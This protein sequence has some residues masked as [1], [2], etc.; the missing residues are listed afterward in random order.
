MGLFAL[1]QLFLLGSDPLVEVYG[2]SVALK[3]FVFLLKLELLVLEAMRVCDHAN[4]KTYLSCTILSRSTLHFMSSPVPISKIFCSLRLFLNPNIRSS[5]VLVLKSWV[6]STKNWCI[7]AYQKLTCFYLWI[8][9]HRCHSSKIFLLNFSDFTLWPFGLLLVSQ[10][11]LFNLYLSVLRPP[12]YPA[13]AH[14]LIARDHP[15]T[16]G[17]RNTALI[18]QEPLNLLVIINWHLY[19]VLSRV[20]PLLPA[21]GHL[22]LAHYFLQYLTHH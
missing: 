13:F 2:F 12:L 11:L 9:F 5:H 19:P 14:L 15:F 3:D 18:H 6:I 1:R 20:A 22:V 16:L 4:G 8:V 10:I 7:E 17:L 21:L